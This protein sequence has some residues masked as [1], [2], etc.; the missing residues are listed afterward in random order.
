MPGGGLAL[1]RAID[2]VERGGGEVRG[3]RAHR[4]ADPQAGAR[5][6]DA[7]DR[8]ELRRR[9]RRRRRPDARAATGNFGFDAR[10]EEYVDLVEAGIIDPTKVVRVGARERGLGGE[11]AAAH[12]GDADR[13]GGGQGQGA[14]P[15]PGLRV[16]EEIRTGVAAGRSGGLAA[17]GPSGADRV[18]LTGLARRS[19][20]FADLPLDLDLG[21]CGVLLAVRHHDQRSRKRLPRRP[22][23]KS[24]VCITPGT[25]LEFT[26]Q[27]EVTR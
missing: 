24:G 27:A 10:P 22:V 6:A 26:S 5:G 1:L 14:R 20:T 11:R 17:A 8:R 18:E 16:C 12:R 13:G 9:R 4:P 3:R 25:G 21:T 2:A 23:G 15:G 7:P 19:A